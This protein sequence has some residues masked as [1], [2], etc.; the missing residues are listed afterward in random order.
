MSSTVARTVRCCLAVLAVPLLLAGCETEIASSGATAGSGATASETR[1]VNGFTAVE[2]ATSGDLEISRTGTESLT[3]EAEDT[4]LPL[5][6][7]EVSSGTLR[8][9]IEEGTSVSTSQPIIYRLTVADLDAIAVT[10]SGDVTA[11]DLATDKLTVDLRGSGTVTTG[12]S[13]D[14][15]QVEISGSG[16]Y[17]GAD[18]SSD[19]AIV[20]VSGSG[21]ATLQVRDTLDVTIRGSGSVTYIGDPV[22]TQE[23]AGSGEVIRQ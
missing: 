10:G 3:I 2:L 5:L 9:G 15:Q 1:E 18:L 21:D 22:V 13:A 19:A 17:E 7:S 8:L 16:D 23:I 4:V 6:T 14:T 11:P 12:G 20:S